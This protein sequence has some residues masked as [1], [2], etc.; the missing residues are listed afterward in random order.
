MGLPDVL[1]GLGIIDNNNR[2]KLILKDT[3]GRSQK[4]IMT[5]ITWNFNGFPKMPQLKNEAQPIYL[6]KNE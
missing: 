2:V 3:K 4:V 5:P 6:S 1:A